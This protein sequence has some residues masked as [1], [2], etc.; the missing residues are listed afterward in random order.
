MRHQ[1][2][3]CSHL[4][5]IRVDASELSGARKGGSVI[6][7]ELCD[8]KRYTPCVGLVECDLLSLG[9]KQELLLASAQRLREDSGPSALSGVSA[10]RRQELEALRAELAGE[11]RRLIE[12]RFPTL[13][14]LRAESELARQAGPAW[15]LQAIN[16]ALD[17]MAAEPYGFCI[18]CG[19]LIEVERLRLVPDTQVCVA[20]ARK[21]E[22]A[23]PVFPSI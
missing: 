19:A 2:H 17:A 9:E 22:L 10:E 23:Q 3:R 12:E 18:A 8:A 16:R 20:C 13:G 14:R 7:E 21:G 11:R 15:R 6:L 4:R 1:Y 5:L